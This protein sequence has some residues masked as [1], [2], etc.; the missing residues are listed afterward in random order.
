MRKTMEQEN[1]ELPIQCSYFPSLYEER[2]DIVLEVSKYQRD[3]LLVHCEIA[4]AL[5]FMGDKVHLI[6][7]KLNK[8]LYIGPN[9]DNTPWQD[10]AK[11]SPLWLASYKDEAIELLFN[12]SQ[13]K[14]QKLK[15]ALF[16]IIKE[17]A[18]INTEEELESIKIKGSFSYEQDGFCFPLNS[19]NIETVKDD[20][21]EEFRKY[22]SDGEYYRIKITA[23]PYYFTPHTRS[24][25]YDMAKDF[26]YI[27]KDKLAW[28]DTFFGQ[29]DPAQ[30][31]KR[32]ED[33][34]G[35]YLFIKVSTYRHG[36]MIERL[37]LDYCNANR[38]VLPF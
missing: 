4:K 34:K 31:W 3:Q 26:C 23:M 1:K 19:D 2:N 16:A 37:L 18:A 32:F 25:I 10:L 8:V 33:D 11:Q 29:I 6:I 12:G 9:C 38:K 24:T 27:L 30:D 17:L 21:Y 14:N 35:N 28:P 36:Q 5:E 15:D 22:A 20:G 13:S 7:D